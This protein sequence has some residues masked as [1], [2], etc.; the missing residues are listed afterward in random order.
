[1]EFQ[2]RDFIFQ[3]MKEMYDS[4]NE[5]DLALKKQRGFA[6][7]I[8]KLVEPLN[9]NPNFRNKFNKIQRKFLINAT[10]LNYAAILSIE[11]G[12]ITVESIPNKPVNNLIKKK[13]GWDGYIAMDTQLFLALVSKRLSLMGM[14]KKWI[15]G[16]ITMKGITKLLVFLKILKFLEE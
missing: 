11:K 12:T 10:N 1:M 8:A 16:D 13:L 15:S 7:L 5:P 4:V 6:G 14:L 2:T 9:E 3:G